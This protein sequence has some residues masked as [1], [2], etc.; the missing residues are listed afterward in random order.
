MSPAVYNDRLHFVTIIAVLLAGTC[1]FGMVAAILLEAWPPPGLAEHG[2]LTRLCVSVKITGHARMASWV[3]PAI[4]ARTGNIRKPSVQGHTACGFMPW[5][6]R[7]PANSVW[8][9]ER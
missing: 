6:P 7:L 4:S 3:S 2:Y 1:L 8:E 5:S 9:V